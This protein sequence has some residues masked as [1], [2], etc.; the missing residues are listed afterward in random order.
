[1]ANWEERH[2]IE[3]AELYFC[4]CADAECREKV[5]LREADYE[6]VRRNSDHFLIVPGHELVEVETVIESHDDWTVIEKDPEVREIVKATDPR[7]D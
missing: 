5:P 4:E 7:R 6:R 2:R 3:A 1:M